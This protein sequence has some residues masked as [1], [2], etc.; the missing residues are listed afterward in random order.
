MDISGPFD[1]HWGVDQ[2]G[3]EI[4]REQPGLIATVE[5]EFVVGHGGSERRYQPLDD[6]TLW[7]RFGETCRERHG[8]L[9]F[10]GEFGLLREPNKSTYG[11]LGLM[12]L[13]PGDLLADTLEFAARVRA[14]AQLLDQHNRQAAMAL[15]NVE[16]PT[17]NQY[18]FWKP[19]KPERFDYRWVPV[20][21]RDAILHQVGDAITGNRQFRR[22]V[23]PG[24]PNWF[25]LG[26]GQ[27]G[28]SG[29]RRTTTVRRKFC[30]DY[31]RVAA[32]RR[33][34]REAATHA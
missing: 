18:I 17:M 30:S 3:Y 27:A 29:G 2:D 34:K 6:P 13:G 4:R 15:F 9:A 19:E 32:A 23:N 22:C 8:V 5:A 20:S 16:R 14:I 26:P 10:T 31:C 11:A 24:C 12:W 28:E 1:F 33:Q 7:L 21:L 25:R